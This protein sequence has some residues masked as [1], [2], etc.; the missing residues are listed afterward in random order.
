[1]SLFPSI[2]PQLSLADPHMN[3]NES[4]ARKDHGISPDNDWI[5]C[6]YSEFTKLSLD[7][8]SFESSRT[9]HTES[10]SE[11]ITYPQKNSY[12]TN[13]T[14]V[15][16]KHSAQV[17]TSQALVPIEVHSD[18]L[19]RSHNHTPRISDEGY[20][21]DGNDFNS[22]FY[23]LDK[24]TDQVSSRDFKHNSRMRMTSRV[25]TQEDNGETTFEESLEDESRSYD[26]SENSKQTSRLSSVKGLLQK[27]SRALRNRCSLD[28]SPKVCLEEDEAIPLSAFHLKRLLGEQRS[29]SH[30]VFQTTD[31]S[32]SSP[33]HTPRL[34]RNF[35]ADIVE[36]ITESSKSYDL[37][38]SWELFCRLHHAR[39]T[40]DFVKCMH[41][42]YRSMVTRKISIWRTLGLLGE[43]KGN[44]S[45]VVSTNGVISTHRVLQHSI[46]TAEAIRRAHPEEYWFQVVG[47]I[48]GLGK[49]LGHTILGNEPQWTVCGETFPVGCRFDPQIRHSHLFA[50][51]PDKRK[52]KYSTSLGVYEEYCGL[53][54][55]RMSWSGNEY[56]YNV[57][58]HNHVDLPEEA[59]FCIRYL[60]FDS[61]ESYS[62]LMSDEDYEML[63]W[64]H[65]L[66]HFRE[67]ANNMS[68][69]DVP[70][71]D[72]IQEVYS[73]MMDDLFP[74]IMK[75]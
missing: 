55:V 59:Y 51:N 20:S 48:H 24:N 53:S 40:Y 71:L 62:H 45:L 33:V 22:G 31:S 34:S 73:P 46:L 64:L 1:M 9:D 21:Q 38:L 49:M 61:M 50:A 60:A 42:K 67:V 7:K 14:S 11:D 52:R 43:L 57:L 6:S 70:N 28:R 75:W 30:H 69:D 44:A 56:L 39:Q 13:Q 54:K 15:L 10:C 47:L 16:D 27:A 3:D 19:T 63:P 25:S 37:D 66:R 32:S 12:K 2:E 26:E 8:I 18:N 23:I 4:V 5:P 35:R 36:L 65:K 68:K 58:R 29:D 17:A 41:K 72:K 74:K